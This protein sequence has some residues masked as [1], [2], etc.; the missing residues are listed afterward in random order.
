MN[1]FKRY[2]LTHAVENMADIP[3]TQPTH[4]EQKDP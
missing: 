1:K 2:L 3:D 4:F